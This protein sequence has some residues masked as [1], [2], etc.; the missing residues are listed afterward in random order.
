MPI[1]LQGGTLVA[2]LRE[3]TPAEA[4]ALRV[5]S[6]FGRDTGAR[7]ISLR[8][9]EVTSGLTPGLRNAACD[10]VLFVVEGDGT[11][12]LDGAAHS[13]GP[14]TGIYVKAG[15][16]YAISNHG[17]RPM[18]VASSRCPD[19]ADGLQTFEALPAPSRDRRPLKLPIVRLA[20]RA[21]TI[22]DHW[23]AELV[24]AEVGSETV[25]QFVA[26]I[27]RLPERAPLHRHDHEEV[28]FVL[29]GKGRMWS[30]DTSTPIV[31]GSCVFIPKGQA[32]AVENAGAEELLVAGMFHPAVRPGERYEV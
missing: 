13:I 28:L 18:V 20:D 14:D 19:P 31:A 17:E 12:V 16:T 7:A 22:G 26:R 4:D 25:T 29:R 6:L 27:A 10:E 5:W 8:I 23:I 3:G 30:G 24:D 1:A 9:L 32:H 2:S 15:V 11:L 21:G